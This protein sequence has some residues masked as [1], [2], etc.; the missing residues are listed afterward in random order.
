[1]AHTT[2]LSDSETQSS[3]VYSYD[4]DEEYDKRMQSVNEEDSE[5]ESIS[6]V[7][8]DNMH[9]F[10]TTSS[11]SLRFCIRDDVHEGQTV[12]G[13]YTYKRNIFM[14]STPMKRTGELE[15]QLEGSRGTTCNLL[16]ISLSR[17]K[18]SN[19]YQQF[20]WRSGTFT[21]LQ[22]AVLNYLKKPASIQRT[23]HIFLL[24]DRVGIKITRSG[25]LEIFINGRSEG[26][27]ADAVY[28]L[29]HNISYYPFMRVPGGV[30]LR[31]T[32][33]GI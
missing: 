7:P 6:S 12:T 19:Y 27:M 32:A 9:V 15:V 33:G 31:L 29:G 26:I 17:R 11:I 22:G 18:S 14:V 16:E 13:A 30:V 10:P 24:Y 4:T 28:K 21:L 3:S 1:M 2:T 25:T 8:T 20:M 23:H 5:E